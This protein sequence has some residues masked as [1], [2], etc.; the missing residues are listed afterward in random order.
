MLRVLSVCGACM[1]LQPRCATW[2]SVSSTIIFGAF[3]EK[4]GTGG[5]G[6]GAGG[7]GSGA[8]ENGVVPPDA[9]PNWNACVPSDEQSLQLQYD[10]MYVYTHVVHV[11]L[12]AQRLQHSAAF[13]GSSE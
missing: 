6:V 3:G 1:V 5:A 13:C 12:S 8:G 2:S 11:P 10:S 9:A 4:G 7:A